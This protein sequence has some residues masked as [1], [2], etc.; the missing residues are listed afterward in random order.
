MKKIM[1]FF[2][3]FYFFPAAIIA[4]IYGY[5]QMKRA[6]KIANRDGFDAAQEFIRRKSPAFARICFTLFGIHPEIKDAEKIPMD[7]N[8]IVVMNHQSFLDPMLLLGY[9][10]PDI[11]L[12]AKEELEKIPFYKEAMQLFCI[13]IDRNNPSKAVKSLRRILEFLKNG[14]KIGI[15]PEGTR[16]IDGSLGKFAEGSLKIAY[17]SKKKV[18]P[19]LI[20]GSGDA[21]PKGSWIVRPAKVT[22]LVTDSVNAKDFNTFE[23]YE[24]F[25]R[26]QMEKGLKTIRNQ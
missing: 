25:I 24:E 20:D 14:K 21:M 23:E 17:K 16:S 10:T 3:S 6:L 11:F 9:L 5:I 13:T 2:Y 19:V 7:E 4:L 18:I 8:F 12:L 1:L 15:F 22:A 26:C